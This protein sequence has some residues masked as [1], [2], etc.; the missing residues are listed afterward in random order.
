[1]QPRRRRCRRRCRRRWPFLVKIVFLY[2]FS[3][4]VCTVI[5]KRARDHTQWHISVHHP[6]GHTYC[7]YL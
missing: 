2:F 1:M 3:D 4:A 5:I 7:T 6:A